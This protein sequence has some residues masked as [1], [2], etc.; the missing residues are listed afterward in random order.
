MASSKSIAIR[1]EKALER[2]SEATKKMAVTLG[3]EDP[4]VAAIHNK[5]PRIKAVMQLEAIADFL[6]SAA[7]KS[8][9]K[10]TR[11]PKPAK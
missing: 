8:A 11:K 1:N 4:D 7:A 5:Q 3:I 6:E 9:K 10:R 2:L